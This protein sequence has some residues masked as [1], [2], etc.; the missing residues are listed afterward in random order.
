MMGTAGGLLATLFIG[1]CMNH[2]AGAC[3]KA[4]MASRPTWAPSIG[5]WTSTRSPASAS[6]WHLGGDSSLPWASLASSQGP[7]ANPSGDATWAPFEALAAM[8]C[9]IYEPP[10]KERPS[11]RAH[12]RSS[13]E[14]APC[15]RSRR[16]EA[17]K[18]S[19]RVASRS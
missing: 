7:G 15:T 1:I 14:L 17:F 11:F 18:D 8:R 3:E 6:G 5:A 4:C 13:W 19:L 16:V 9:L 12:L 2:K 10:L